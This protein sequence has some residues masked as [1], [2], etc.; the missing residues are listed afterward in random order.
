MSFGKLYQFVAGDSEAE[1]AR[2][3]LFGSRP[4]ANDAIWTIAERAGFEVVV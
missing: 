2:A 3:R 4:P 1:T